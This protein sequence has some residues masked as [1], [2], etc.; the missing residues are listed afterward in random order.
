VARAAGASCFGALVCDI[1]VRGGPAWRGRR[2][3]HPTRVPATI[4]GEHDVLRVGF[5]QYGK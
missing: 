2:L 4:L 3:L 5:V 1:R